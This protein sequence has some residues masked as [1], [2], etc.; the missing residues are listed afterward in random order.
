[1]AVKEYSDVKLWKHFIAGDDSASAEMY[2]RFYPLLYS[3]GI[4]M[5]RDRDLVLDTIQNLFVKLILNCAN[6]NQTDNV[7]TYLLCAFRHKLL[8]SLQA[9]HLTVSIDEQVDLFSMNE[10]VLNTLF[11][12]DD[13]DVK[14][15]RRL[16]QAMACLTSHQ[17]E[18]IYLYYIKGLSHQ[19]IA[20]VLNMNIQS[21]KNLLSRTLT[22]LRRFFF[23]AYTVWL[24]GCFLHSPCPITP[25]M[26]KI[27]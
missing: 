27:G 5:T 26:L 13:N 2:H 25:L 6:L 17:R 8:D 1:M 11:M 10:D 7:K 19:E 9:L 3:Y 22:Y 23:S 24:F 18:V 14:N 20:R 12:K 15:E 4:R 16:A 21:S